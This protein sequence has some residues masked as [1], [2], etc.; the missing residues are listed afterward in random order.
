MEPLIL[1]KKAEVMLNTIIYP[2]LVLFPKAEKFALCQE[3]KQCCYR[4]IRLSIQY[5]TALQRDK[6][7][8]LKQVDTDLKYLLVLVSVSREQKY[9]TEKKSFQLQNSIAELGRIC[10]GLMK[11]P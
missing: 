11:N 3:I 10:G 4:I 1:Q 8:Y 7:Y 2:M 5:S 9:I 6:L